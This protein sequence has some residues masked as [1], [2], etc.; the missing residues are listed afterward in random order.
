MNDLQIIYEPGAHTLDI[1]ALD[2]SN[3]VDLLKQ[4][5]SLSKRMDIP[6]TVQINVWEAL[7]TI[8]RS[9]TA[10]V[11]EKYGLFMDLKGTLKF[12]TECM[13]TKKKSSCLKGYSFL[14]LD[15]VRVKEIFSS[16]CAVQSANLEPAVHSPR[17]AQRLSFEKVSWFYP[18]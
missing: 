6:W 11:P 13:M 12:C 7:W 3:G 9:Y 18:L 16:A 2:E 1:D 15:N 10:Q 5:A 17:Y 8:F 4:V 14:A